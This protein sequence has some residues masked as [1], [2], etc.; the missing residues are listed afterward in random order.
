MQNGKPMSETAEGATAEKHE[1]SR[2]KELVK[3]CLRFLWL[4]FVRNV[5]TAK[6]WIEMAALVG[7]FVYAGIAY[8]QWQAQLHAL[9]V[10]QRAWVGFGE[11]KNNWTLEPNQLFSVTLP[12]ENVGK[13]PAKSVSAGFKPTFFPKGK[14]PSNDELDGLV[15]PLMGPPASLMLPG[16]QHDFRP[17]GINATPISAEYVQKVESGDLVIYV[18]AK[19]TYIDIFDVQHWTR[20]CWASDPDRLERIRFKSCKQYNEIDPNQE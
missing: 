7:A 13:T 19:V 17:P 5:R 15:N 8:V 6:M 1:P 11:I 3:R 9:K 14:I 18:I 16:Q 2:L 10:D 12:L 20:Y 4:D